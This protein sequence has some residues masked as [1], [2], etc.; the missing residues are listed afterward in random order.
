MAQVMAQ[1]KIFEVSYPFDSANGIMPGFIIPRKIYLLDELRQ[2]CDFIPKTAS[3]NVP[4]KKESHFS[5][6]G[7]ETHFYIQ[8]QEA[9]VSDLGSNSD[10]DSGFPGRTV[11]G[12]GVLLILAAAWSIMEPASSTSSSPEWV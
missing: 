4:I 7:S 8:N 12:A 6:R 11:T 5:G 9:V 2:K 1:L 10:R 3:K